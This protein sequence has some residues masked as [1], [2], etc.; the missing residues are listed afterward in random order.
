MLLVMRKPLLL[1]LLCLLALPACAPSVYRADVGAMFIAGDG[2]IALQNA[3]GSLVLTNSQNRFDE[4]M[5]LGDL[6]ASP[7]VRLQWDQDEHRVRAHGFGVE[8]SGSG[9]LA[10]DFGG[11]VAGTQVSTSMTFFSGGVS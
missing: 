9:T 3:G 1:A 5:G 10:N 4:D 6:E 11:M 8:A 7:Y 2:N